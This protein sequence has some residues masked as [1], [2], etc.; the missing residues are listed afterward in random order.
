MNASKFF[1][2]VLLASPLFVGC[3]AADGAHDGDEIPIDAPL[4]AGDECD[5]TAQC[6]AIYGSVANDCVNSSSS[7]SWCRCGAA[8]CR[9]TEE[10]SGGETP[11]GETPS[12]GAPSGGGTT[13]DNASGKPKVWIISDVSDK[14][15]K[16]SDG[17]PVNDPDDISAMAG[18]ML[19]SNHFDTLGIVVASTHRG[20]HR[21]SPD[22]AVWARRYFGDA[23]AAER[24]ALNR[25]IGGYP[26]S[27][28]FIQSSIKEN[29]HRFNESS[30]YASLSGFSSVQALID[31]VKRQDD[32]VNVLSWGSLT[33]Q[34]IFVKHCMSTPGD[35]DLLR[36]VRFIAH[37]TNSPLH[38]GTPQNPERV[39]NCQEDSGAC[40]Y[41]KRM[42]RERR[43]QYHELGAIGQH[44]IVS[45]SYSGS[46]YFNQFRVSRL[47]T[48]FITGKFENNKVD[49]S[50]SATYWTL[51]SDWGVSLRDVASNGENPASTEQ[52][53]EDRFRNSSRRIHDELLRRAQAASGR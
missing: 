50:D 5:S 7:Q 6:Q 13:S 21:T 51:L 44:G 37:W 32:T 25:G 8:A 52:R 35:Q 53:N 48:A 47:G 10:G 26:M 1:V 2:S 36:K 22:Q 39:A 49:H 17:R 29:G 23:F 14:N 38:Q 24:S 9:E 28:N 41:L 16:G 11:S 43:I 20:E 18:Y 12:V 33:E 30:S 42:A 34:A 19:V 27:F 46:T 31:A 15:I 3:L 40:S 4:A 45:G